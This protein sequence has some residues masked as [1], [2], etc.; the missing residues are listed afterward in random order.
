MTAPTTV[1]A[2]LDAKQ[3]LVDAATEVE[4]VARTFDGQPF[5]ATI[6]ASELRTAMGVSEP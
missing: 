3:A 1:T 6:D 4:S 2:W 5:P